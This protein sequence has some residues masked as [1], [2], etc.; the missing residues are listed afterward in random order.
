MKN[1]DDGFAE[2]DGLI[3]D[4]YDNAK[5]SQPIYVGSGADV[6]YL[7]LFVIILFLVYLFIT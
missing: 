5:N 4:N 3:R 6:G 2:N 7:V 1:D